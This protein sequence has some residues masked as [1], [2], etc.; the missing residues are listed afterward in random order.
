MYGFS[1]KLLFCNYIGYYVSNN[2]ITVLNYYV[3]VYMYSVVI[4]YT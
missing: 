4:F 2:D 3:V 1:L